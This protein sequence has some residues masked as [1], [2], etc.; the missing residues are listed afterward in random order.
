M[1]PLYLSTEGMSDAEQMLLSMIFSF[2]SDQLTRDWTIR[3][4]GD[5]HVVI[6]DFTNPRARLAWERNRASTHPIPVV[7]SEDPIPDLQWVLQKPIRTH[8]LIPFLNQLSEWMTNQTFHQSETSVTSEPRDDI[9]SSLKKRLAEVA[10]SSGPNRKN[11]HDLKLI[12]AGPVTAGK[13]TAIRTISD[14][15]PISTD[16]PTSDA[17]SILR[18]RT[19]VAM[20]YGELTLGDGRKLRLYGTPGQRRFDFM[21]KTLCRGA[22]GLVV[23]IDNRVR[24]P[25]AELDY[26]SALFSDL[27]DESAMVV[28]VTHQDQAPEPGLDRY[29]WRLQ[30]LHKPWPVFPVDP[31]NKSHVITLLDGLVTMLEPSRGLCGAVGRS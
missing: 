24:N 17:V 31:R 30:A 2:A 10:S 11:P 25:M 18:P 20:D 29:E 7:L 5:S 19:T 22:L 8:S 16:V 28:G 3:Q 14:I 15:G 6:Y 4:G 26:Y 13:S 1:E 12:I 9:F 27:V 23:L 21:S